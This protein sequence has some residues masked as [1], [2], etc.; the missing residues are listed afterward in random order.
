[1]LALAEGSGGSGC[2]VRPRGRVQAKGTDS[3]EVGEERLE[4]AGGPLGTSWIPNNSLPSLGI[5]YCGENQ[6]TSFLVGCPQ[7]YQ[8]PQ[9]VPETRNHLQ[10]SRTAPILNTLL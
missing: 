5:L 8:W 9:E 7:L 4:L 2:L 6:N 10:F 3:R 1:M